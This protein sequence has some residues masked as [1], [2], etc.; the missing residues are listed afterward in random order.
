MTPQME[1]YS[2]IDP[3]F[4]GSTNQKR[5][6]SGFKPPQPKSNHSTFDGLVITNSKAAN[7][8]VKANDRPDFVV[9]KL[10]FSMHER[11]LNPTIMTK[12]ES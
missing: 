2:Q 5:R 1:T 6:Q 4:I 10:D 7:I 8:S 3:S 11:D 12:L 9:R